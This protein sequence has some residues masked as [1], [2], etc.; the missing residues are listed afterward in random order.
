MWMIR[1]GG[2][3][4]IGIVLCSP[5]CAQS[6]VD[7]GSGRYRWEALPSES[8]RPWQEIQPIESVLDLFPGN[9]WRTTEINRFYS[10]YMDTTLFW[11]IYE[12]HGDSVRFFVDSARSL[13]TQRHAA[14][15]R[16]WIGGGHIA[17]DSFIESPPSDMYPPRP[18]RVYLRAPSGH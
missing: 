11:G 14:P 8:L 1:F 2:A 4:A 9:Q 5:S 18:P 16:E 7:S 15:I 6:H 10:S 17:R 12:R 13:R 3:V